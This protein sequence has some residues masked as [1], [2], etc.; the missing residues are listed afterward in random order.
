MVLFDSIKKSFGCV[1]ENPSITL[2]LVLFLIASQLLIK[3]IVSAQNNIVALILLLT[4]FV[5]VFAYFSGWFKVIK[6]S[7]QRE[8]IKE[9]NF[10][11][12]FL[13]GIGAN[14]IPVSIGIVNYTVLL[15]I[16]LQVARIIATLKFGDINFLID[17]LNSAIVQNDNNL[18]YLN[19]LSDSQKNI[20]QGWHVCVVIAI[21]IFNF[22]TLFYF[23]S[24]LY[25]EKNIFLRPFI[26][27][28]DAV[29]FLF[30]NFPDSLLMSIFIYISNTIIVFLNAIFAK[31]VILSIILLL[32]Y[33]YFLS[34][35]VMLIFNYYEEKNNSSD[36]ADCLGE[37]CSCDS[38]GEE[39]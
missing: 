30:K 14:I 18:D 10:Y 29:K 24:I 25:N 19:N 4:L 3:Y 6:E 34:Y 8:K 23:P 11:S 36:R 27:F 26:A 39:N 20:I 31:N 22:L 5:L 15:L 28:W 7:V 13:E 17:G 38:P 21:V 37:N 32:V 12:I 9:N 35:V 33:I 2:F 16:I 1:I